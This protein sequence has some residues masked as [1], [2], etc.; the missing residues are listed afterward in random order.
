MSEQPSFDR[1]AWAGSVRRVVVKIGSSL[2]TS[3]GQGLNPKKIDR[4]AGDLSRLRKSGKEVLVV[5]SG[6][7]VSGLEKLALKQQPKTLPLKQA[8]AAVGQ[9]YLMWAY[10]R[11]FKARGL[12]VAQILL[13]RDDLTDRG[14]FLNSRNTLTA[15]L[16]LGVIP[17]INENDTVAVEEIRFGDNDNLAGLVTH[18]A[19]AQLLVILSDVE[20]LYSADP[21][22]N[23]EAGLIPEVREVTPAIEALAGGT[24][25]LEGVGGMTSKIQTAKKVASYGV[26]TVIASGTIPGTLNG[27]VNG[28]PI[29]TVVWPRSTR[30]TSRKQWIAHTLRPKGW[31]IL[32][33]GAVE[34]IRSGGRSLLPSGIREV[35]GG[36]SAGDA[37]SCMDRQRREVAKGLVNYDS[38]EVSRI[39]GV[40]TAE[41]EKILGRK[42]YDEVI[43]RDNLVVL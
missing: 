11:S 1:A 31:L 41:I 25:G 5:S 24:S 2:L 29:G 27:I 36:F 23:A 28:K 19:D 42:D 39:K 18:L 7:I 38:D 43:H 16:E 32:D 15:L 8:A 3:K 22:L 26:P 10:E 14:R 40:K 33:D 13:N 9:S 17:I 21:R 20:G 37:V 35:D 6:A 12:K 4:L 34:A 30:L